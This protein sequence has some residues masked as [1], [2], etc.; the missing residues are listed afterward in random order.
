MIRGVY[1]HIPPYLRDER[2]RKRAGWRFAGAVP[3]CVLV[4]VLNVVLISCD[5]L[6]KDPCAATATTVIKQ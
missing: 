2:R 3:A 4:V 6:Q 1:L 5:L